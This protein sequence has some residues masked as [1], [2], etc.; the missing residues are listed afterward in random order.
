[1]AIFT[2]INFLLKF[3][4][5]PISWSVCTLKTSPVQSYAT[6]QLIVPIRKLHLEKKCCEYAPMAIFTTI[7]FLH[8]FE[9]GPISWSVCTWQASPAQSFATL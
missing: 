4:M 3:E 8:K 9:M 7:N 5:G 6:L 1:M 2:T